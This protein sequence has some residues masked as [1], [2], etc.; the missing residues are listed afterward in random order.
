M[1]FVHRRARLK[2]SSNDTNVNPDLR[3]GERRTGLDPRLLRVSPALRKL[4]QEFEKIRF[5]MQDDRVRQLFEQG[6]QKPGLILHE[7]RRILWMYTSRDV[8]RML[9]HESG[10][11]PDRY[12]EWLSQTLLDALVAS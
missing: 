11:S 3:G 4:E 8:Y 12:Q 5:E 6:R 7:A 1:Q 2:P 10:W 9:V